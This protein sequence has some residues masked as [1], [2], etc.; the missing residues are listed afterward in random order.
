MGWG[1]GSPIYNG[2]H[3]SEGTVPQLQTSRSVLDAIGNTPVV[4]LR[5]L[6]SPSSADVL[7]KLEYISP[8]GSYKDRLAL[9]MVTGAEARGVLKAFL[10]H[11]LRDAVAYMDHARRRTVTA[12]DIVYAL[13]RQ[14][15]T[16]YGFG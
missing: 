4:K 10:E 6:T 9:A 15:R 11:V 14:G 1:L 7:V 2:M 12:N 5:R 16:L 3:L 8:T 13:K